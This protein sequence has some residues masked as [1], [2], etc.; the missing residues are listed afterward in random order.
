MPSITLLTEIAEA[1]NVVR[2]EGDID[3][4]LI[5]RISNFRATFNP[6]TVALLLAVVKAAKEVSKA[7]RSSLDSDMD[8]LG[9][10]LAA[11]EA[12]P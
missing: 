11:L 12:A 6:A 9:E 1:A 10:A 4:A 2:K 7:T 8:D 5:T 3:A